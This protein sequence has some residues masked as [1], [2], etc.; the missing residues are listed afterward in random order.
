MWQYLPIMYCSFTPKSRCCSFASC[1]LKNES[2]TKF[3]DSIKDAAVVIS[4]AD[5]CVGSD[6]EGAML[7]SG[8]GPGPWI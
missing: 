3:D 8:D 1:F 5:L 2:N 7:W 6:N 4:V